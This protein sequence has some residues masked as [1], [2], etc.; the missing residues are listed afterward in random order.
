L[1]RS[2]PQMCGSRLIRPP[3]FEV[4]LR[5]GKGAAHVRGRSA[6]DRS[7]GVEWR[8]ASPA[9]LFASRWRLPSVDR[10]L[11]PIGCE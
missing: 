4:S 3:S 9:D 5:G 7:S 6:P 11:L 2:R 10:R 1:L 8:P